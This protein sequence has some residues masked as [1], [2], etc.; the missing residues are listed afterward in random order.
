[1]CHYYCEDTKNFHVYQSCEG[2][3]KCAPAGVT[4]EKDDDEDKT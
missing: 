2:E 1:V 3:C 4:D